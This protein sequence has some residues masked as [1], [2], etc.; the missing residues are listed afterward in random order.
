MKKKPD[1]NTK[2]GHSTNMLLYAV[3][4]QP[5]LSTDAI[6]L[7][8]A[9]VSR[10]NGIGATS[11]PILF[12]GPM[13]R[14]ILDGTKTQTR[15]IVKEPFQSWMQSATNPE[16]FKSVLTQCPYGQIG[17]KLW[18]RETWQYVDFAG[19]D[20]GYVYR[21]TDPDWETMEEWKWKPSIFMPRNACRIEL[22]ITGIRVER[23]QDISE[24]D[25]I[26]EGV[27]R[28]PNETGLLAYRS[29]LTK[30]EKQQLPCFPYV[31]YRT[32]WQKI[33][34]RDSW[35]SNPFVWI[36]EFSRNK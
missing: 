18:V 12:S 29:Y 32:L 23:L 35:D 28:L 26:N 36:I 3:A 11:K 22:T 27:E 4:P 16:W 19:E 7:D 6:A 10:G 14:A 33:N 34:G 25:A 24:Q 20:N 15:R 30:P 8:G 31:S 9:V 17:N 5:K 1:S 13:V 21:A 2:Q